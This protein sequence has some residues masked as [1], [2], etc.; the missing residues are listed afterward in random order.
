ML[1]NHVILYLISF[2]SSTST[3]PTKSLQRNIPDASFHDHG[4]LPSPDPIDLHAEASSPWSPH[5][6]NPNLP[7]PVKGPS[8]KF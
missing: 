5:S 3:N 1:T 7:T 2:Q 4:T 8:A 6:A